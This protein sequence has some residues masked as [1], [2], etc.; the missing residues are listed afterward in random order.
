[1]RSVEDCGK[2]LSRGCGAKH[3]FSRRKATV[4]VVMMMMI[5]QPFPQG[6]SLK[7]WVRRHPFF[8]GKAL[9]TRLYDSDDDA[10][11]SL[12][13]GHRANW[14]AV[15]ATLPGCLAKGSARERSPFA[16]KTSYLSIRKILIVTSAFAHPNVQTLGEGEESSKTARLGG[17]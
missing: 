1:M 13:A 16:K 15:N 14:P 2:A 6:F 10:G 8:E 7:K 5:V 12:D 9:G 11:V 17:G 4:M 3:H